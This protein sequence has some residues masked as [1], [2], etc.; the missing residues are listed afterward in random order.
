MRRVGSRGQ[1]TVQLAALTWMFLETG[2]LV[3]SD[4]KPDIAFQKLTLTLNGKEDQL[5]RLA[6]R[7]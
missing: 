7:K 1:V 5:R 6:R 2:K 4:H 3:L